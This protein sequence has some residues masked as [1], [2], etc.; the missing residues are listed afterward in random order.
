METTVFPL[1]AVAGELREKFIEARLH[2]D[3]GPR[4]EENV[5]LQ[6]EL[7]KSRANPIYVIYD[8]V[9]GQPLRKKAGRL[10]PEDFLQLLRG[11]IN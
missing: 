8:P 3:K 1:P 6:L 2:Y 9:T 5:E 7:G 4:Q 11:P 10:S